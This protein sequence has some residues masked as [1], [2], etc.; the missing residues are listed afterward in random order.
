MSNIL[1]TG[2]AGYIGSH[3]CEVFENKKIPS[4]PI[5][6]DI[7]MKKYNLSEGKQLGAKLTMIEEEWVNNS[8]KISSQEIENII[9]N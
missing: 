8:F 9:N 1:I 3:I 4:M 6:A 7:L 5:T 2:G